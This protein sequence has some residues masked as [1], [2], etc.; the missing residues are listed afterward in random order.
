MKGRVSSH[1]LSGMSTSVDNFKTI[2]IYSTLGILVTGGLI[3]AGKQ[4]YNSTK[5]NRTNNRSLEEGDPSTLARQLKMAFENDM[6]FG[7]GTNEGMVE[8]VFYQIPSKEFFVKVQ[9]A[10]KAETGNNLN[11]DLAEELTS[12]EYN[13]IISIL[14]SRR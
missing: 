12:E 2:I 8:K 6:P 10:Y 5:K 4:F 1:S 14:N 11:E 13:K 3:L 9:K 7:W